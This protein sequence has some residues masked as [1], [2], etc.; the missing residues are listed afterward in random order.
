MVGAFTGGMLVQGALLFL[1]AHF[2]NINPAI[3]V[4]QLEK[5]NTKS[6]FQQIKMLKM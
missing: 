3:E 2:G 5:R 1:V 6:P 4:N